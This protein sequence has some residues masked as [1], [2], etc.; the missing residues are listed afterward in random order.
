[1]EVSDQV[2]AIVTSATKGR[3]FKQ[4]AEFRT[5]ETSLENCNFPGHDFVSFGKNGSIL[6]KTSSDAFASRRLLDQGGCFFALLVNTQ[7]PA[8]Y[9]SEQVLFFARDT[10]FKFD[11]SFSLVSKARTRLVSGSSNSSKYVVLS[12][13]RF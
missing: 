13:C 4:F 6:A 7:L 8:V 5:I 12:K 3:R 2:G 11:I 1:M 9:G 10:C